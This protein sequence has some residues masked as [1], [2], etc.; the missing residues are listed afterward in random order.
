[1]IDILTAI[2]FFIPAG[3]ANASPVFANKIPGF[4]RW[5]TPLDFGKSYRGKRIL[6]DN[7][8]WRGLLGGVIVGS[9]TGGLIYAVN[10]NFINQ[11]KI[12]PL[13]P[14]VDTL[15]IGGMLGFGALVGDAVESFFKRQAGVAPGKSWFPFDQ[16]DYIIGGLVFTIP[17]VQLTP[18]GYVWIFIVWFSMHLVVSYIGYLLHFKDTPI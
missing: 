1:M 15:V 7:K 8:T 2:V 11:L 4:N 9:L 5:Q 12:V 17:L 14:F 3:L 10:P 18:L 13:A 6:G 16:V